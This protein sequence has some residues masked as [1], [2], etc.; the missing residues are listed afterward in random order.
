MNFFSCVNFCITF[1]SNGHSDV[2]NGVVVVVGLISKS[3]IFLMTFRDRVSLGSLSLFLRP[4]ATR[5][6]PGVPNPPLPALFLFL[7][8]IY[9]SFIFLHKYALVKMHDHKVAFFA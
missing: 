3:L 5:S 2:S 1:S 6:I 7:L 4:F 8:F 9:N